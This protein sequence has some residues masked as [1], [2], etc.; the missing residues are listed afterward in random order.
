MEDNQIISVTV[1]ERVQQADD[2]VSLRLAPEGD[3][4]LPDWEPGSHIDLILPSGLVRQYSL[5]GEVTADGSYEV[6][7]LREREGRGASE[8][9]HG[10]LEQGMVIGIRGPRNHFPLIE[11]DDYLF[12]AGGIGVT[13]LIPMIRH[14]EAR[15]ASWT[16]VYGG[17]TKR[18]MAYVDRLV[19][20]YGDRVQVIPED[21]KGRP[22]LDALLAGIGAQTL[23]Y[24]C[25]PGALLDAL[26]D[27]AEAA[28]VADRLHIER[29]GAAGDADVAPQDGDQPFEL[30][31]VA[32]GITVEVPADKSIYE[33]VEDMDTG[34]LF[35]CAEGY[36]GTCEVKVL[37]G[38]PI[39]RDTVMSPEEHEEE[40][41]MMVCVGRSATP[42]LQIDA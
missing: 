20:L 3:V 35:S 12:I 4:L 26:T 41:T 42:K 22:D 21:E 14:V 32:S 40:G 25:G 34:L 16:L 2:V 1:A 15:G 36:C 24:S 39:H 38:Q 18:T 17:R 23:V 8:E 29:F 37:G 10:K 13:P 11:A 7:I 6:A 27:R 31:L 30:E 9:V 28:G 5:C 19:E 33:V